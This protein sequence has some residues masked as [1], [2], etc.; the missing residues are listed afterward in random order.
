MAFFIVTMSHPEGPE[1]N[2]HV[3]PHVEYL[4]ELVAAGKL[5]ASGP[6]KG[7]PLRS[8]FLIFQADSRSAVEAL[9]ADDP[10]SKE[11][12]IV[13]LSIDEWDPLF[14]AFGA[15]SSQILPPDLKPLA[16]RLGYS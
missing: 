12:L 2:R 5:K 16:S 1:W 15:E 9:V 13:S 11:G 6:M 4:L 14:G 7:T 8:G 3:L 10:F